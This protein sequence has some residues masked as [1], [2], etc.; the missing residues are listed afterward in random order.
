MLVTPSGHGL[1]Y[2]RDLPD[3]RDRKYDAAAKKVVIGTTGGLRPG[4]LPPI[5]NQ[6][7][8]GTCSAHGSL[9]AFCALLMKL[10]VALPTPPPPTA[11][12]QGNAA[13]FSR[14]EQYWNSGVIEGDPTQDSGRQVR[15]AIKALGQYGVAPESAWPYVVANQPVDPGPAVESEGRTHVALTYERIVVGGPG[16][17]MRTA[18][19]NG[20]VIV[21]GFN[22]PSS[23]E[24]G[25][26]DPSSG[27]PLPL[28][29]PGESFIGGHCV[30]L[31][32]Y[33]FSQTLV[34]G[35]YFTGRSGSFFTAD[36]SW[37]T[38]WGME[39]RF[40]IDSGYFD[41]ANGLASDFWVLDT[42]K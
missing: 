34:S 20:Q 8:L 13:P 3:H 24:D 30:A 14:L 1:G 19:S 17:P 37:D 28:P 18:L 11:P 31:T 35:P 23:F 22:V 38:S 42:A 2:S 33:D 41:P 27:A 40:N 36:N 25:S 4:Q 39:G 10:G 5:W 9:R 21:I 6:Q 32:Y 15:D 29:G 7:T 16:A 12:G 26:W